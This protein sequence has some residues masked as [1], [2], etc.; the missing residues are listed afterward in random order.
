MRLLIFLILV[1]PFSL[2]A[3]KN[4]HDLEIKYQKALNYFNQENPDQVSDNKALTLFVDLS[5]CAPASKAE[6]IICSE[7]ALKSGI[8]YESV[9]QHRNA[10]AAYQLSKSIAK[11]FNL[12]DSLSFKA[13]LYLSGLYFNASKYDSC[14]YF[15]ESA[16]KMYEKNPNL[17][18]AER[19]FNS[20][21]VL[22]F[23]AGNFRQS[24]VNFKK[25][26]TLK[27][28]DYF[29]NKNNQALALQYLN[30]PEST[31]LILKE[32]EKK[33]PAE[34]DLLINIATT[35]NYLEKPKEALEYLSKIKN[36]HMNPKLWNAYGISYFKI[37]ELKKSESYLFKFQ[38]LGSF[39]T[40]SIDTG[41]GFYYLGLIAMQ[42]NRLPAALDCFQ[43]A[44]IQMNFNF[45]KSNIYLNPEVNTE[46]FNSFFVLDVLDK[47]SQCFQ[48][49]YFKS[50]KSEFRNGAISTGETLKKLA[51]SIVKTYGQ[52]NSRLDLVNKISPK[53]KDQV[54]FLYKCWK[55]TGELEFAQRAFELG[56]EG[57]AIVLE[58]SISERSLL[59][60][61]KVPQDLLLTENNLKVSLNALKRKIETAS[62]KKQILTEITDYEIK[63]ENL[64]KKLAKF[65]NQSF[66]KKSDKSNISLVE[67]QKSMNSNDVL[68]S[69]LEL[70]DQT[71]VFG[72][73]KNKFAIN[74]IPHQKS[75]FDNLNKIKSRQS[76]DNLVLKDLYAQLIKPLENL[77]PKNANMIIIT[78]NRLNGLAFE[79]LK[80]KDD[81]FLIQKYPISYLYSAKF[82]RSQ[83]KKYESSSILG[84]A[85]FSENTSKDFLS[86]SRE[87]IAS[88]PNA[89]VF[90]GDRAS[91]N[92]FIA[93]YQKF[94]VLH[95][96]THAVANINEPEKSFLRFSDHVGLDN[97]F[98][99]YEFSP[100]ILKNTSLVF[101]S[102]CNSFGESTSNG[103]GVRGLSRGFYLA[104]APSIISSLWEADDYATG[105]LSK[106][107]YGHLN[108]GNTFSKSL[109]LAKIDLLEDPIMAQFHSPKYWAS[110]IY[111]GYEPIESNSWWPYL[112]TFSLLVIGFIFLKSRFK[113]KKL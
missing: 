14:L 23:E 103:E 12:H 26:E 25:A 83:F 7:S 76:F 85:P 102:A 111:V 86:N 99:L 90:Y 5:N 60:N 67:L 47:K 54:G 35:Y 79:V 16:E 3:Q 98:Y 36:S 33:F 32:L 68:I 64:N 20:K 78:D 89:T 48:K 50:F 49:L 17:P 39:K 71:L 21:G 15:L 63:L 53:I 105:Y 51:I 95:L 58:I 108:K 28:T 10:L 92:S 93:K 43:K 112:I 75:F 29:S 80:A 104:G 1:L 8:L 11:Q 24:L 107:F 31:L 100:G 55:K 18:E 38:K 84:L 97:K 73:N 74:S 46:N 66:H 65:T 27:G 110:L 2:S 41:I 72:I 113:R 40:K 61:T 69:Y 59:E 56:E 62:N 91:K 45:N 106:H 96:A 87:E 30:E 88:I 42:E 52:E 22:L 13:N 101:L 94:N 82:F 109:Q 9:S 70:P 34:N 77:F 37:N 81:D 19:L 6:S 57:K 44:L 4:Q